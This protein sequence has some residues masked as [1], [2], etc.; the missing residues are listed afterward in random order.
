MSHHTERGFTMIE[1][2]IVV[3]LLAIILALVVPG[4]MRARVAANEASAIAGLRVTAAAQ[5]AYLST[6]GAGGYAADFLA[7][8]RTG[9]NGEPPFISDNLG[10]SETPTQSGYT[11]ALASGAGATAGPDDCYG[12]ATVTNYYATAVPIG[13]GSTGT[14]SFAV[15]SL[16]TIWQVTEATAPSEPFGP[17]ATPVQ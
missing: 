3:G 13:F 14:R 4:L 15:S 9:P 11:Y 17:P 2:L 7:L 1:L 10:T 12:S 16:S 5:K 6:C 8:G